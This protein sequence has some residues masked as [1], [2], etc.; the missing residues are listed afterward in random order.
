M[1]S[2]CIPVYNFNIASLI[3]E[4]SKQA[5]SLTIEYEIIVIDDCS[6]R[7][8]ETNK[9]TCK[10]F[11]Y[12]ELPKNIGRASIRNLFLKYA[13]F[14]Y[15]LFI[16]CDSLI[17]TPSLLLNYEAAI[18]NK[19]LVV[20]GGSTYSPKRP[21]RNKIL[22]WKYGIFR[23]S[24]PSNI[25]SNIPNQSFMTNNFLIR[26]K[27]L[28]EIK[29]DERI[30]E[31]GHEDTL[32]GLELKNNNIVI[33]HIN[34]PVL[35]SELDT[36]I[37]CLKKTTESILNLINILNDS[38]Y[39]K[40]LMKDVAMLRFYNKVKKAENLIRLSFLFSKPIIAFLL[41]KGY[42]DLYLFDYYKLGL[43]I[44]NKKRLAKD[45]G[46]NKKGSEINLIS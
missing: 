4:L 8:L 2:I 23:E 36:N 5:S 40:E 3:K 25:R 37:E 17:E 34:N 6:Q 14:E 7:F 27:I 33:T 16:D 24:K 10:E 12:I 21:E 41:K 35:N 46:T 13:Q 31:Y 32:F 44:E 42:V 11:T 18:K 29:F 9:A 26:K 43:F 20:C 30:T 22:K 28:E 45:D 38:K 19:P 39:K 15:L 1:I